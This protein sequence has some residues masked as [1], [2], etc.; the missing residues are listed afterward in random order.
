MTRTDW[1]PEPFSGE[2]W[3]AVRGAV[4]RMASRQPV[5]ASEWAAKM[6]RGGPLYDFACWYD[7]NVEARR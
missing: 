7:R 6:A 5:P 1:L 2:T 4:A 3:N